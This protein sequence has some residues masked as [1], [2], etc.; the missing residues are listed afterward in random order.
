MI[1]LTT[2]DLLQISPTN[3]VGR[4]DHFP[5]RG[6]IYENKRYVIIGTIDEIL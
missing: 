2:K 4:L 5:S 6:L 1:I 3:S